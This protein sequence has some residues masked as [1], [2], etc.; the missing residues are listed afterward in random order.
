MPYL[1]F[2]QVAN[3]EYS[4]YYQNQ[5]SLIAGL[6]WMPFMDYRWK[7][8]EWLSKTAVFGEWFGIGRTQY[9]K[10][11]GKPADIPNYDLRFGVKF[12]SRR[13]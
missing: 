5:F 13:F 4:F 11:D 3:A 6:R 10:Q 7:E 8:N 1:R 2:E 12:S 9:L